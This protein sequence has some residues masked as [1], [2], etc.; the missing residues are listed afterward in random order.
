MEILC[1]DR[2]HDYIDKTKKLKDTNKRFY[3]YSRYGTGVKQ[4][5]AYCKFILECRKYL[6]HQT[7]D[8]LHCHDL[9]GVIVGWLARKNT[10]SLIFDM[11]EFY[12]ANSAGIQKLRYVVRAVV[13]FFQ[14]RCDHLIYVNDTQ[15]PMSQ[16]NRGKLVFCLTILKQ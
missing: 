10:S 7:Y 12:E 11:H 2:E 16:A 15:G 4:L 14:N 9:D 6:A 5:F 1:W 13:S 3:P 8:Y